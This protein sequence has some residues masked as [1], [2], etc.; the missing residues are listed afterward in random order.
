MSFGTKNAV[1]KHEVFG[2]EG[3]AEACY[4]C[5]VMTSLHVAVK[6]G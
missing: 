5:T 4:Y 6:F 2:K 3:S 1:G